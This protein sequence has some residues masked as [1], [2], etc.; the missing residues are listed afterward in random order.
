MMGSSF[1]TSNGQLTLQYSY[2]QDL[3]DNTLVLDVAFPNAVPYTNIQGAT[4]T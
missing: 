1:D 4:I 2:T 3:N